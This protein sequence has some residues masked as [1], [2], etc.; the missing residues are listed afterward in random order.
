[1]GIN[2]TLLGHSERR[3]LFGETDEIVADKCKRA[4]EAGLNVV[5]CIG[6]T[7]EERETGVTMTV[8]AR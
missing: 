5:A 1:M 2:W 3:T 7:K 6:E 4:L 8:V